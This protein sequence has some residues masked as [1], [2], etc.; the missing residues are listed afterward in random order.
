MIVKTSI[1]V[2]FDIL[3]LYFDLLYNILYSKKKKN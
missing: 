3:L 1:P 2:H